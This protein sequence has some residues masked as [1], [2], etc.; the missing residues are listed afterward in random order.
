VSTTS[1]A[2][3]SLTLA[4]ARFTRRRDRPLLAALSGPC[5]AGSPTCSIRRDITPRSM[6]ALVSADAA[7][8]QDDSHHAARCGHGPLYVGE[9][10]SAPT[11]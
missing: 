1:L 4:A 6:T 10:P 9:R 2:D 5:R 11:R 8:P 3:R 7:P